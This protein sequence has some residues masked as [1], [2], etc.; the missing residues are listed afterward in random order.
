MKTLQVCSY[1]TDSKLYKNLFKALDDIGEESDVF[2]FCHNKF[3][4]SDLDGDIIISNSYRP[5]DRLF[6]FIK[7]G[8]VYKDA[9]K[10]LDIG[11]YRHS[12]AHSLMSNGYIANRLYRDFGL[13][14]IVAIRRTDLFVFMKYKPY[15]KGLAIRILEEAEALIFLSP[16]FLDKAVEL[17]AGKMGEDRLRAKSFIIPNGIDRIF[18]E[19]EPRPKTIRDRINLVFIGK[20]S[21]PN[22]NVKTIVDLVNDLDQQGKDVNLKLIGD[23]GE[24]LRKELSEKDNITV[25]GRL[26]PEEIIETL[27]EDHIFVMPSYTETFGLV[28][29]EAMS[30]GLPVIYTRGQGF[31]GQFPQGYIGYGVDPDSIDEMKAAI[32]KISGDYENMSARAIEGSKKF[33]WPDI[34][35]EY[36]SIYGQIK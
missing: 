1:Y 10:M 15:L 33:N 21:D 36:K 31:D 32:E 26:S 4:I 23:I 20:V 16:V 13:K 12:H 6:F 27:R 3:D 2:Y 30:Q 5:I 24:D 22:K 29:V 18:F 7:H 25:T 9:K 14:Y 8:K 11:S 35:K 17:F 34:A 28:Y 19:N